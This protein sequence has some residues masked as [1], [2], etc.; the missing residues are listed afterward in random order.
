MPSTTGS[1]V[2]RKLK[3]TNLVNEAIDIRN[4]WAHASINVD[5]N[6]DDADRALDTIYRILSAI[7]A[8]QAEQVGQMRQELVQER[9]Q[10][11]KQ[12][13]ISQEAVASRKV[14][15]HFNEN[16][17]LSDSVN[18][19]E[20]TS[21][22]QRI[23]LDEHKPPKE[24]EEVS[25]TVISS[26]TVNV[27]N[28]S[29]K[30]IL[31]NST[32]NKK[33]KKIG[34]SGAALAL[35]MGSAFLSAGLASYFWSNR[36]CEK[37]TDI[38]SNGACYK[39]LASNPLIIGILTSPESYSELKLYLE[40]QL[41]DQ[42]QSVLIKGGEKFNYED[43][44]NEIAKAQWDIV[45]AYSPMNGMRTKDNGY[46]WIARMFP[47]NP[48]TY[49]SALYVRADSKIQSIDD[50][51]STTLVA[52]G[53]YSSASSFYMPSY[54]LYGKS[55]SVTRGHR[56]REIKELVISGS[57]DVGAGVYSSIKDDLNFRVIHVSRDIP[58]TG[59]YLSPK[60][61]PADQERIRDILIKAPDNIKK[62]ANYGAGEETNYETFRKISVRADE[63]IS[64]ADFTKNPVQFFC[65]KKL[66][67]IS[68]KISGFTT[69]ENK[70]VKLRF[71]KAD[72]KVCNILVSLQILSRI[73]K[74]TSPGIINGKTVNILG[75][76]SSELPDGTCEFSITDSSQLVVN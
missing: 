20:Q 14:D 37:S 51:K 19:A 38:R 53:D 48:P 35:L 65:N 74:G 68:G 5:F 4:K 25:S 73:P 66:D 2:W 39:K 7:S 72:N 47:D 43:A 15:D 62:E 70:I 1:K 24:P 3:D 8:E 23:L 13:N 52:L 41:G 57:A 21:Q 31:S 27:K 50:I 49:Q 67:G 26:P 10:E 18:S 42:V 46:R 16:N 59:V 44:Q 36:S 29:Y 30:E 75:T 32:V 33:A 22:D 40:K 56:G 55:M 60:L 9:A 34:I 17:L 6:L 12:P 61:S 76:Q 11:L 28:H 71:V 69:E 45:F 64:C 58:G 63:A 54:D